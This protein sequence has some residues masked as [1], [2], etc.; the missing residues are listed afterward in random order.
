MGESS[1]LPGGQ[2]SR[3]TTGTV[4]PVALAQLEVINDPKAYTTPW[5]LRL[6]HKI[7]LDTELMDYICTENEKDFG[8][9]IGK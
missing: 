4:E 9:L 3:D 8:H 7:V 1:E 6:V 5:T 2:T